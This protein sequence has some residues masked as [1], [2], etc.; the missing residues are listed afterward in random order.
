MKA[1]FPLFQC[2]YF[3]VP[4]LT[5]PVFGDQINNATRI[6]ES[7]YGFKMSLS[8]FTREEFAE[9]LDKLLNDQELR[10]KWKSASERIRRE[11]RIDAVC[12]QIAKY[13]ENLR[14]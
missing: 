14:K 4:C 10:G 11:N 9:K 7:G 3:G 1:S 12:E 8:N 13:V 5:L 2:F 6:A